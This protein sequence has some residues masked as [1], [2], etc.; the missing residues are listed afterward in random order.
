MRKAAIFILTLALSAGALSADDLNESLTRTLNVRPGTSFEIENVNGSI[1]ISGWDQ[2]QV[3]IYA[4]KKVRGNGEAA[5]QA[6]KALRVEVRQTDR[7]I[8]I[9]TIYPKKSDLGIFDYLWGKEV[10]ASVKYEIQ[11]PRSMNISA[12]TVNGGIRVTDI[13]GEIELDT[14][15]GKIGVEN[16]SGSVE[17]STT[18]GGIDVELLSVAHGKDMSFE[19]TNGRITLAVPANLAAD[20]NASTT[21][22]SVRSDLPLTMS[23]MSRT[24]IRGTLNGGGPEIKLRTT[25]GG[26]DIRAAGAASSQS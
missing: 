5:A 10:N 17:A 26:I 2:P 15:N 9:E 8:S 6:M 21:N 14:T 12:D 4:L 1:T 22:G 11:V 25:N 19:T 16:C 23:R 18:N 24:S 3:R 20:I 13:S 7:S